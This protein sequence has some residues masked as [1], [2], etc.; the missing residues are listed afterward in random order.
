MSVVYTTPTVLRV[1]KRGATIVKAVRSHRTAFYLTTS[2]STSCEVSRIFQYSRL[3]GA[4]LVLVGGGFRRQRRRN[5]GVK[6]F[7]SKHIPTCSRFEPHRNH[8]GIFFC[9]NTGTS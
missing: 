7:G 8:F 6:L 4:A 5:H 1:S 9:R 2:T 3:I